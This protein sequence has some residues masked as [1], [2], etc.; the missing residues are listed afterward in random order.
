[1]VPDGDGGR[2]RLEGALPDPALVAALAGWCS[3]AGWLIVEL[4][5]VGGSLED[6]YLELV[7]QGGPLAPD[8]AP[9]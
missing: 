9:P 4:R 3:D 6:V 5:T 8:E 1:V 2:Y 7:G